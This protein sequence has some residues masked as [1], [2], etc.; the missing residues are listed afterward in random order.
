MTAKS[1]I[2]TPLTLDTHSNFVSCSAARHIIFFNP[3][4]LFWKYLNTKQQK[5]VSAFGFVELTDFSAM[6]YEFE[7]KKI[8]KW[9][10]I[11]R[12]EKTNNWNVESEWLHE[13]NSKYNHI[14]IFY[15][16]ILTL[17]PIW[18]K[19]IDD[20]SSWKCNFIRSSHFV[21]SLCSLCL[22]F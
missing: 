11:V 22:I 20:A 21:V 6:G 16:Q 10:L 9:E 17:I 19:K 12:S 1:S 8:V 5:L 3:S 14:F 18:K 2:S 13:E 4:H 7:K 15:K